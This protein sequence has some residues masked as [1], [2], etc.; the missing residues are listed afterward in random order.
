MKETIKLNDILRNAA[1][2]ELTVSELMNNRVKLCTADVENR[3][4]TIL[5]IDFANY[6]KKGKL[7][8]YPV[9][10]FSEAP[11]AFYCGGLVLYKM[12]KAVVN[13]AIESGLYDGEGIF[14]YPETCTPLRI[15]MFSDRTSDGEHNITR[16][17]I[18]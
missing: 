14:E 2:S 13:A 7:I 17:T 18:L 15:K 8:E 12:C 1:L 11:D 4:V 16:V 6:E 10:V 3:E 5:A 9:L